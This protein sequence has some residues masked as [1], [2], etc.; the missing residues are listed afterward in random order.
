MKVLQVSKFY[1]PVL[2]GI[3]SVTWELTEGLSRAGIPAD[4]LCANQAR[5]TVHEKEA[6]HYE[7]VRAASLGMLLSTSMSPAMPLLLKR[8]QHHYDIVH[9][10]MPDPMAALAVWAARPRGRVV[11]H[12]HSDVIRQRVA[13]KAYEPLQRW[14]LRR[15]DA[16]I[17]TSRPYAESSGPLQPWRHKVAVIPIGISDNRGQAD[18]AQ[19]AAI[20]QRFRGR[21]LVFALGRMAYY[22]GFDVLIDAAAALPDHCA[23]LIGGHGELLDH[24]RTIVARRGLA[25]KVHLLGHILDHELA[26]HFEACDVFCMPST[27]RAEAYGVAIVEAMVMGK[28]I[29]ATD[30]AGSGVPWVNVD[31]VTGYNAPVRDAAALATALTRLLNDDAQRD[32]MGAASRERYRTEFHAALM[33]ERTVDLYHRVVAAHERAAAPRATTTA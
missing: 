17:A 24:Y 32:R 5:R 1:P 2:G 25:G 29:V 8:M 9:V 3:E 26:S 19:V 33:T 12:W 4:V 30:I 21:R 6:W 28:P 16:I 7:V 20:R 15:A 13:L 14:L 10:H 22:K 18:P 27:V 11:V 23:V 31:G